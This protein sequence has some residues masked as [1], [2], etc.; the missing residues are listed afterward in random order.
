MN[1]RSHKGQDTT[2]LVVFEQDGKQAINTCRLPAQNET[3]PNTHHS[4][5]HFK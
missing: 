3:Q 2:N 4:S 1:I 5:A